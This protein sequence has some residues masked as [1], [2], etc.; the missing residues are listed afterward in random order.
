[1]SG[2]TQ[3]DHFDAWTFKNPERTVILD[4]DGTA[5]RDWLATIARSTRVIWVRLGEELRI[6]RVRDYTKLDADDVAAVSAVLVRIG[7]AKPGDRYR[8]VVRTSALPEPSETVPEARK[9]FSVSGLYK[10]VKATNAESRRD[11][12]EQLRSP[13][14]V[15]PFVG[16]GMSAPY[17]Y[18]QW[19]DFLRKT[20]EEFGVG[21][22]VA[23]QLAEG[24]YPEA[25]ETLDRKD[26]GAFAERV[27]IE[28][29]RKD[30]PPDLTTGAISYLPLLTSGPVITTN[31]DPIV[32]DAFKA[33]GVDLE[34]IVGPQEQRSVKAIHQ[35]ERALLQ[36]HGT[37]QDRM[38][39]VFTATEYERGYEAGEMKLS[40][41]AMLTFT[42]RPL[43]VLGA[44]LVHDVTVDVIKSIHERHIGLWH[45]AVLEADYAEADFAK[46][47]AA[48]LELGIRPLWYP[49]GCH[50][51]IE[52]MLREVVEEAATTRIVTKPARV[53]PAPRW[54]DARLRDV[55][56]PVVAADAHRE[57]PAI[58]Q[59]ARSGRL[60]L[61]LGA[62][63]HLDLLPTGDEFYECL[64]KQFQV[65]EDEVAGNRAS[66]AS[67]VTTVRP[68]HVL[69]T[70]AKRLVENAEP[71]AVHRL[72]AALP[73][74][75][76]SREGS[77]QTWLLTTNYDVALEQ[78]LDEAGEPFH[79]LYY[80]NREGRFLHIA[81]DG[82]SRDICDPAAIR[83][84]ATSAPVVV[85]LNG[86][87]S[88]DPIPGET[89]VMASEDFE[90]FKDRMPE[91]LP[92]CLRSVLR[93][94]SLLFLGHGVAEP[95]IQRIVGLAA[96]EDKRSWAVRRKPNDPR[97]VERWERHT[98][99]LENA[100]VVTI[101]TDLE[102]FVMQLAQHMLMT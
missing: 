47:R 17:G 55:A 59:A 22:T 71:T 68:A 86:G 31:F 45:Y 79:L 16:A 91:V 67:I 83:E 63:A 10:E 18:L 76:R 12:V 78:A 21:A 77:A 101:D 51:R 49:A 87:I 75:V 90:R 54:E 37:A 52:T 28:F 95:D 2:V 48:M 43:L 57:T 23:A 70:A 97:R 7:A 73:A 20:A 65:A 25:A 27:R 102:P 80:R 15:I 62:Y 85:K 24:K 4:R 89:A 9:L 61:V 1:M 84:L 29:Q 3:P 41:L 66:V 98:T 42:N 13:L 96:H 72:A 60:V 44:S 33:A 100:G 88:R 82:T 32:G 56:G 39:R 74:F 36:I 99:W 30:P 92:A 50:E 58:A 34:P 40:V 5:D 81:P 26:R 11:L 64:A 19:S 35:N 8:H 14:K 6:V 46:R 38:F 94:G 93:D 69:W 53:P